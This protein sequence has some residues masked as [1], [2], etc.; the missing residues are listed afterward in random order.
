M[1]HTDLGQPDPAA[2]R[3]AADG[4]EFA[5]AVSRLTGTYG[6]RP[7]DAG[8]LASLARNLA[9]S[10]TEAGL[11][12]HQCARRDPLYRLGRVCLLPVLAADETGTSGI[13]V[14][15]TTHD[16][17]LCD[18]DR[19]GVYHDIHQAMNAAL[20]CVLLAFGYR[21]RPFGSGG[22]WLVT[23]YRGGEEAGR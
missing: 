21:V 13:S 19:Y 16:L 1:S 3:A 17:L 12:V 11:T 7:A 15:W 22:A 5:Q 10:L 18:Q 2:L 8:P 4:A 23:G 14:S 6:Y 20:G 9:R